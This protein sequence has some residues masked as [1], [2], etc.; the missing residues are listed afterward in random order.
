MFWSSHHQKFELIPH[1]NGVLVWLNVLFP[2]A[3]G[4]VPFVTSVLAENHGVPPRC[5]AGLMAAIGLALTLIWGYA[6]AGG[7]IDH[8]LNQRQKAT[9]FWVSVSACGA[10]RFHRWHS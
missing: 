9:V 1:L 4:L 2:L 8:T 5:Y 6:R 7:L 3:I 10:F